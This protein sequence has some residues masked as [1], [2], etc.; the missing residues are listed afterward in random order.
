MLKLRRHFVIVRYHI[1]E[2]GAAPNDITNRRDSMGA[3]EETPID[4][5]STEKKQGST[6]Y[7]QRI[8]S[9]T[10]QEPKL[11]TPCPMEPSSLTDHITTCNHDKHSNDDD[12]QHS[13]I[14]SSILEDGDSFENM[15]HHERPVHIEKLES[16]EVEVESTASTHSLCSEAESGKVHP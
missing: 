12:S 15:S 7:P 13:T 6:K 4:I 5:S 9:T 2:R 11:L 1:K 10:V 16:I 3:S 14:S 8:V